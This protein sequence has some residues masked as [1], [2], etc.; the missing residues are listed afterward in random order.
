MATLKLKTALVRTIRDETRYMRRD[1]WDGRIK[2][3]APTDGER[4]I[5]HDD[6]LLPQWKEFADALSDYSHFTVRSRLDYVHTSLDIHD[7]MLPKEVLD[8][9]DEALSCSY[10]K[11]ISLGFNVGGRDIIQFATHVVKENSDL[12]ELSLRVNPIEYEH[13]F[14]ELLNA[15]SGHDSLE[16]LQLPM[17]CRELG[18]NSLTAVF[19]RCKQLRDVDLSSNNITTGGSLF[20][21]NFLET[22]KSLERLQLQSN[23]LDDVDAKSIARAL[24]KNKTLRILELENNHITE[25]GKDALLKAVFNSLTLN[26]IADSNHS[27]RILCDSDW[28]AKFNSST[29]YGDRRRKFNRREKLCHIL[30]TRNM[31]SSN[32]LQMGDDLNMG[33]MPILLGSVQNYSEDSFGRDN[34]LEAV[35]PLSVMYEVL[36]GWNMPV[37]YQRERLPEE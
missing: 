8:L 3:I 28:I 24:K 32:V 4:V 30:S 13:D 25:D 37:L 29:A 34:G 27:C 10:F 19:S 9:L 2:L 14:N 5:P 1:G 22:N 21:N 17:S 6:I 31:E 18:Y 15:I 11:S 7:I 26:T 36:R 35:P 23:N 33:H 16:D 20:L 12:D